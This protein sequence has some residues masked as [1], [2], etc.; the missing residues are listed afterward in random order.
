MAVRQCTFSAGSTVTSTSFV[1]KDVPG[2]KAAVVGM[3]GPTS[4]GALALALWKKL[5]VAKAVM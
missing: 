4:G 3:Q 1:T 2:A 5:S